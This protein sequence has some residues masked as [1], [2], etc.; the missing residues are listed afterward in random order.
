[1]R[2]KGK[3]VVGADDALR[4]A[5]VTH[6]HTSAMGGH[7]GVQATLNRIGTFFYWKFILKT[8]GQVS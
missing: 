3:W 5:M 1:L 4:Q 6:F 2:R 7:S 8:M